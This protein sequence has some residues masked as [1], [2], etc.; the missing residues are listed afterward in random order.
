MVE[1]E[2]PQAGQPYL[3]PYSPHHLA[4]VLAL[5]T[6]HR[7][8]H[9]RPAAELAPCVS[10]P[11]LPQELTLNHPNVVNPRKNVEIKV[12]W[13]APACGA[14]VLPLHSSFLC[15]PWE[16]SRC[17]LSCRCL[18]DSSSLLLLSFFSTF[19]TLLPA[20]AVHPRACDA[21]AAGRRQACVGAAHQLRLSYVAA[22]VAPRSGNARVCL[23]RRPGSAA[24]ASPFVTTSVL[25]RCLALS[26]EHSCS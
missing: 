15:L 16:G 17:R 1:H 3:C 25:C 6:H 23:D 11:I 12:G 20:V 9:H 24:A 21:H 19:H 2:R 10:S 26:L 7:H 5:H 22:H 4:P 8:T 18:L 13:W 14:A